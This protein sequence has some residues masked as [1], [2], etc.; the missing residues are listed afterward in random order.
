MLNLPRFVFLS[1]NYVRFKAGKK[2]INEWKFVI[3]LVNVVNKYRKGGHI[4][5]YRQ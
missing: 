2:H 1:S 5:H 3:Y 4:T